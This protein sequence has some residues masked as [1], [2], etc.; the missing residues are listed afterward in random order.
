MLWPLLCG[1]TAA[2]MVLCNRYLPCCLNL[3]KPVTVYTA[4]YLVHEELHNVQEELQSN[5]GKRQYPAKSVTG[6][7]W[8]VVWSAG[9][10]SY[11]SG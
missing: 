4:I 10:L 11:L 1:I 8:N 2:P 6:A 3:V 5:C 7:D 9:L